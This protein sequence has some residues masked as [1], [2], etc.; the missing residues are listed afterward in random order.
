M[1]KCSVC[2]R[3]FK[4][5]QALGG[6][7]V[8]AHSQKQPDASIEQ[9]PKPAG[10]SAVPVQSVEGDKP[11]PAAPAQPLPE[12]SEAE[13]IRRYL[14]EG[15]SLKQLT[16]VFHFKESTIRQ[17]MDKLIPPDNPTKEKTADGDE[18]PALPMI[19]KAGQGQEV[20]SPEGILRYYFLS[21]GDPGAWMFKGMMLLRAAQLMNL[22]DVEI[23]K[24]QADAQAKAIKPILDVME[25]ARKDMDAAEARAKESSMAIAEAAAMG[26]AGGV[27]GR[28][29]ARF[30]ELKQQ[31]SDIA[32]VQNP[33]QGLMARTMETMLN[34]I[35]SRLLGGQ[36]GQAMP[37]PGFVDKRG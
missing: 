20:I 11:Q 26:A 14:R 25:Q 35:T 23:M 8:N 13:Q 22:T 33:M 7:M 36:G 12:P 15:R 29:D 31:K 34:Q 21:D 18:I 16:D 9:L 24:G 32:T 4:S 17:E 28:I 37:T 27:L 19:L 6:H 5:E 1:F 3:R 2:E 30:E 10:E